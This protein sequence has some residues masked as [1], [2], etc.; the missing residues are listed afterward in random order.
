MERKISEIKLIFLYVVLLTIISCKQG[1]KKGTNFPNNEGISVLFLPGAVLTNIPYTND[2]FRNNMPTQY[3]DT[4][5][6]KPQEYDSLKTGL[7]HLYEHRH[8]GGSREC[9]IRLFVQMDSIEL[10]FG[11]FNCACDIDGHELSG[12]SYVSYLLKCKSTYYNYFAEEDLYY[13]QDI[14]K[15][16]V[17]SNYRYGELGNASEKAKETIYVL[18]A[19]DLNQLP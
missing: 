8:Q 13:D 12:D 11:T 14:E 5:Y 2:V 19:K 7:K 10:G 9:D 16:G 4:I 18:I 15:Y 6:L 17:P 1:Y 3:D